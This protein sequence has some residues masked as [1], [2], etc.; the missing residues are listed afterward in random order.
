MATL[1]SLQKQLDDRT[2]NPQD[3]SI[4]Q[5]QIID[6]LI[7]RGELKGPKMLE[8]NKMRGAAADK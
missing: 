7:D 1:E 4:K 6:E 2:L 3:L 8:L 5:R